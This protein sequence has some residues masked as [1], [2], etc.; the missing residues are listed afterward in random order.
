MFV[1]SGE[2]E[3]KCGRLDYE[4]KAFLNSFTNQR[5]RWK[6][7][8]HSYKSLKLKTQFSLER[9]EK[10][11]RQEIDFCFH[12]QLNLG[13]AWE[14]RLLDVFCLLQIVSSSTLCQNR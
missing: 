7:F 5:I 4:L 1:A 10:L 13:L 14:S 9:L 8:Q 11:D 2:C 3:L 6:L 12:L